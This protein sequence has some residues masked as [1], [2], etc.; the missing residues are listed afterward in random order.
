MSTGTWQA[1]QAAAMLSAMHEPKVPSSLSTVTVAI[2]CELQLSTE[3][4]M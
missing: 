3:Q 4:A 2:A 1:W